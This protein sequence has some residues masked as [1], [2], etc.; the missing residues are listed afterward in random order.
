MNK[1]VFNRPILYISLL[2]EQAMNANGNHKVFSSTAIDEFTIRTPDALMNGAATEQYIKN[3]CPDLINPG[4]IQICDIQY[5]LSSIKIASQGP[6]L[7]I[8]LK[9]P[10]CKELDP[11]DINLQ[12][13]LPTLSAKKWFSTLQIDGYEFSFR[14]PLY[15][16]FTRFA[17][18]DFRINKQL[19][20]IA[21]HESPDDYM[22]TTSKLLDN[23]RTL[24]LEYQSLCLNEISNGDST[25]NNNRFI[26]EWLSQCDVS[27]QK[28]LVD[29]I[30]SAQKE[31]MLPDVSVSCTKCDYKFSAPLDLDISNQFRQKIIPASEE[32]I[33]DYIKQMGEECKT[34]TN[35]LLKM[36]WF[37][38]GSISYT[39]AFSLSFYERQCIAKIIE[40]N[41]ELTKESGLPIL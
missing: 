20:Q 40:G 38:R 23:Q 36:I 2:S 5:L 12:K 17:I 41:I 31:T 1:P 22:D 13:I 10:K 25:T 21:K 7:E 33:L 3:C 15:E 28:Q 24:H 32:D 9:C 6:D 4:K 11:Y 27:L 16:E 29:Y 37:M 26:Y 35:D 8:I 18:S 34:I 30:T 14:S 19:N 39:E